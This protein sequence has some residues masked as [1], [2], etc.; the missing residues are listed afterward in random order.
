MEANFADEKSTCDR[1]LGG[2][3]SEALF[4]VHDAELV[5]V[6]KTGTF[7]LEVTWKKSCFF[8][9]PSSF[10]EKSWRYKMNC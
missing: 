5:A 2:N 10:L 4:I 9:F 8:V 3:A 6:G 1:V 7:L